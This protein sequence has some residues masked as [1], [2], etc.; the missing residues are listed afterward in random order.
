MFRYFSLLIGIIDFRD[1]YYIFKYA[2]VLSKGLVHAALICINPEYEALMYIC[3]TH[4]KY[5]ESVR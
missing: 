5:G 4:W 1:Y 2:Q 3:L